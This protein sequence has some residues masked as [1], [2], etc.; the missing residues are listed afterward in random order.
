MQAP[1]KILSYTE[2][3]SKTNNT[4]WCARLTA[5]GKAGYQTSDTIS[6][7]IQSGMRKEQYL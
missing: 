2:K 5:H 1:S 6:H 4:D 7:K 3:L